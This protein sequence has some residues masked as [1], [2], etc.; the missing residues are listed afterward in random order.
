M[1]N[2]DFDIEAGEVAKDE[3]EGTI[4]KPPGP[5]KV[6]FKPPQSRIIRLFVVSRCNLCTQLLHVKITRLEIEVDAVSR[7]TNVADVSAEKEISSET[8]ATYLQRM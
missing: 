7:D 6:C 5:Y 2:I 8:P 4:W 1:R 3:I